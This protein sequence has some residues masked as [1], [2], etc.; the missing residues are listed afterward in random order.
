MIL[1]LD[2][3]IIMYICKFL[4][5]N[6]D[7]I[8]MIKTCKYLNNLGNKY[9]YIKN[10]RLSFDSN[11]LNFINLYCDHMNSIQKI[12]IENMNE[13]FLWLPSQ[14]WP[15]IM[16]FERC[17]MG[18]KLINPEYS[19]TEELYIKDLSRYCN[20]NSIVKINWDK[21]P[22]LRIL[23]VYVPDLDYSGIEKCEKLEII[24]I[25]INIYKKE[26]LKLKPFIY[27]KKYI[28]IDVR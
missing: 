2:D 8:N 28:Y 12:T 18:P 3:E 1:N 26:I 17:C 14:V 9:G 15:K 24:K 6:F 7:S 13:P 11:Y 19:D 10:I 21:L 27:L 5:N 16:I 25:N 20:K 23:D 4:D 22:E